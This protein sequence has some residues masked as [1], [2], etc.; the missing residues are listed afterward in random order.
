MPVAA[1]R[2]TPALVAPVRVAA[3]VVAGWR[4]AGLVIALET[5]GLAAA[6]GR[7]GLALPLAP[8]LEASA[9]LVARELVLRARIPVIS[10]RP[11]VAVRRPTTLPFGFEGVE[12]SGRRLPQP[13]A[14]EPAQHGLGRR[15]L[16]LRERRQQIL[17]I[18]RAEGRRRR[19]GDDHPERVSLAHVSAF[20]AA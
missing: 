3:V 18:P 19:A 17:A 12:G 5:E 16:Q 1:V 2:L 9:L 20:P 13:A 4:L 14:I 10:A 7:S 6:A 11:P 15:A 8:L